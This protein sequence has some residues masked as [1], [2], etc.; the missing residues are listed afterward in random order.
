MIK[1]IAA[2]VCRLHSADQ[3]SGSVIAYRGDSGSLLS[4]LA[5]TEGG[6][7]RGGTSEI[8]QK[9]VGGLVV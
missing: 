7:G 2:C 9:A 3:L 4:L 6:E 8:S 1:I 5:G